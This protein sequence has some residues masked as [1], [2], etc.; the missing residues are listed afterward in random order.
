MIVPDEKIA[1]T[2]MTALFS[3]ARLVQSSTCG[4]R[5]GELISPRAA[6]GP[7]HAVREQ[8]QEKQRGAARQTGA[9]KAHR[10]GVAVDGVAGEVEFAL[11]VD[12]EV[13]ERRLVAAHEQHGERCER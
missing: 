6:A 2:R 3:S 13:V 1:C 4:R 5:A 10:A 9:E 8:Q 12:L 7:G 11:L